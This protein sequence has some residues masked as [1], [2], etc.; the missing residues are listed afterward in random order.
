MSNVNF[1][2][3]DGSLLEILKNYVTGHITKNK[4]QSYLNEMEDIVNTILSNQYGN[5][6]FPDSFQYEKIQD[7]QIFEILSCPSDSERD[8]YIRIHQL[9]RRFIIYIAEDELDE[10]IYA[11]D[12]GYM[13][14]SFMSKRYCVL[15]SNR[16]VQLMSWWNE[17]RHAYAHE[18]SEILPS[19]R[20][21]IYHTNSSYKDIA[22]YADKLWPNCFFHTEAKKFDRFELSEVL[23]LPIVLNHLDYFN[24]R[25]QQDFIKGSEVFVQIANSQ[26]VQLSPESVKTRDSSDKMKLR[27][28][29]INDIKVR[30]EWHSK[31]SSTTGRIHFHHGLSLPSEVITETKNKVIIGKYVKH[32]ET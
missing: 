15:I 10:K 12:N 23:Y 6:Y 29:I 3:D 26:D 16:Q 2:F 17:S 25:A 9:I 13:A 28:I 4:F 8:L 30:C 7:K 14:S 22:I 31:L 27:D 5:I 11:E 32:L 21:A 1:S 18:K 20:K 24:D 19:Y